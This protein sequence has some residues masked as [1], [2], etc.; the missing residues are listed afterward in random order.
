V[1]FYYFSFQVGFRA[2]DI[3]IQSTKLDIIQVCIEFDTNKKNMSKLSIIFLT[4]FLIVKT[5][6]LFAGTDGI[7]MLYVDPVNG[8]EIA[9]IP[10]L[11]L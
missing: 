2:G 7:T 4:A 11:F 3:Y 9:I 1:L 5:A 10:Y 8:S 6:L